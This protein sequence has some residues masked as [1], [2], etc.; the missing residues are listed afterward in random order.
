MIKKQHLTVV[1]SLVIL[2]CSLC[3]T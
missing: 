1:W 3:F 2:P